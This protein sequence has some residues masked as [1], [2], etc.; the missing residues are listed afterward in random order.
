MG[1]SFTD[2]F[3]FGPALIWAPVR[4]LRSDNQSGRA[5]E[6]NSSKKRQE[7]GLVQPKHRGERS[8][9]VKNATLSV[10]LSDSLTGMTDDITELIKSVASLSRRLTPLLVFRLRDDHL[11]E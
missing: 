3:G 7:T 10:K 4:I 9:K 2:R 1:F 6:E 11:D 8:E 5:A